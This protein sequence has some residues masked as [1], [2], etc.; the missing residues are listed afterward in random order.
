MLGIL[1]TFDPPGVCAR[2]LTE[3]L[4]IQLRERNRFDIGQATMQMM[5]SV[6]LT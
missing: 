2:N 5:I 1:Q 3:C 4:S 6:I